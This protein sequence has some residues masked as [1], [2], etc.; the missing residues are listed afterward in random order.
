V[1][2]RPGEGRPAKAGRY[3]VRTLKPDV[4]SFRT[5]F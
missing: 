5:P 2:N 4:T 3:I 1:R